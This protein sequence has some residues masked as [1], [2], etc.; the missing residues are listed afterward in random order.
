MV[1]VALL[2][3]SCGG[4]N[5]L[6][7][8]QGTGT[9]AI[10]CSLV[11]K[12]STVPGQRAQS[13]LLNK[14]IRQSAPAAGAPTSD[15]CKDYGLS[16]ITGRIYNVANALIATGGPWPCYA[17]KGT[18]RDIP[19]GSGYNIV[20]E[21]QVSGMIAWRGQ[22]KNQ[23]IYGGQTTTLSPIVMAYIGSAPVKFPE[24][25]DTLA[26]PTTNVPV[27]SS[28]NSEVSEEVLDQVIEIAGTP[29]GVSAKSGDTQATID[30]SSVSGADTY[31]VYWSTTSGV[32]L[33]D[34][35]KI[36]G[37]TAPYTH[38]GLTNGIICDYMVTAE[39]LGGE[40]TA[41][42][43]V[44]VTP[45]PVSPVA[46]TGVSA[47][48]GDTQATIDWSSVSGADTYN[49]Y[50]S[51]TSG[52]T[53][54]DGTKIAGVTAP[55]THRGLTNGITCYYMVTAENLGGESTASSEV[56]VTPVPASPVA[57]TGV[58]GKAGDTQ[59]TIGW[60]SV[61]G[62]VSYNV[63]WS[64]TSGVTPGD[65]TKIAGVTAPYTHRGLTNGI[66]CY[67][68]VT[69][70]N[71]GGESTASTEVAVTPVP[72]VTVQ[73]GGSIQNGGVVLNNNGSES[74]QVTTLAGSS[75][76]SGATDAAGKAAQFYYPIG[77]T[78]DGKNIYVADWGN[79]SIRQVELATGMVTTLAGS[80]GL[81]GALD[82]AGTMARF[83]RPIGI[84]T[85]GI[86]LYVTDE[87]SH[88]IRKVVIAT[89]EVTTLAGSPGATGS[90]DAIGP[91][92]Q[93]N[94]P[95]GITTDGL[96]LY[97]SDSHSNAIRKVVIATGEV[98]TL[99]KSVGAAGSPNATGT[100]A[101]FNYPSGITTDGKN[102]F[103]VDKYNHAIRKVV[104]ATGEVTTFA[105]SSGVNGA[106]D[107]TGVA[108]QFDFPNSITTDGTNLYVAEN[109]N[110]TIRKVAI[111]TGWVT[112]LAG[113]ARVI[114][115]T[116]AVGTAARF[117]YPNGITTDGTNLYVAEN[118][119]HTIRKIG[120]AAGPSVL[121]GL[122]LSGG[123]GR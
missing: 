54:G 28:D 23:T 103:V 87:G 99:V 68:M 29:T 35:T 90:N 122:A 48:S 37:V 76:V 30:W 67:Y 119:N 6:T 12:I 49:V 9:G 5:S 107:A 73:M 91:A 81:K 84:T 52:V 50:W 72:P 55:Y 16:T 66:T 36:A 58:S 69:A 2:L 118:G 113:S 64:T 38:R 62:A 94:Y 86:N 43:E 18:F 79:N 98:T 104:I 92:A 77:I 15:V 106:T 95:N 83:S 57:P 80:A 40:S 82:A 97:V 51:T 31:N 75:E 45:V 74:A 42:S 78:T 13:Q 101:R 112:T 24:A 26:H 22:A 71:L 120:I 88:T 53:P 33:R 34:G 111:S 17:H 85:D 20:F 102:L 1:A 114:G 105:G 11:F 41:F 32:I 14:Q 89:G 96:K 47:K 110:H 115:S 21:A 109:G 108:A 59:A 116:D 46:P 93:F 7:E 3:A 63:Y 100:G 70:E 27:V 10:D 56:A 25:S 44:V 61:S 19:V 60:N 121:P 8:N 123:A 4:D 117:N 65:G 39:N